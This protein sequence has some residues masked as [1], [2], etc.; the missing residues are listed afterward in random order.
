MVQTQSDGESSRPMD[1]AHTMMCSLPGMAAALTVFFPLGAKRRACVPP[2]AWWLCLIVG[3]VPFF[4]GLSHSTVPS[5]ATRITAVGKTYDYVEREIHTGYHHDTIYGFRLVPE[6]GGPIHIET[7]ISL[8]DS[9][10]PE[11]FNGRIFRVVYL[12][13]STRVLKN[14]AIEIEILSG[15][16]AG[17]HESLDARPTGAWLFIPVGAAFLAFGVSGLSRMKKDAAISAESDDDDTLSN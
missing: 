16:H 2:L 13:D 12:A 10:I 5:R 8:L 1:Y 17:Y 4:Y 9:A 15:R 7:E 14:E 3:A 11:A 6:V